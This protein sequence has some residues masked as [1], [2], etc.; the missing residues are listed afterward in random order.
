MKRITIQDRTLIPPFG[1]PARDLRLL[2][3][4]LW[5]L[6]RDLLAPYCRGAREVASLDEIPTS[7]SGELLVCKDNLYFNKALIDAFISEARASGKPC[8]IAFAAPGYNGQRHGDKSITAHALRLQ[9]GIRQQ[10][11]VYV[12]DLYYFPDGVAPEPQPLVIDTLP[13]EMGYYHIPQYMATQG[14]DLVFQVPLRAFLSIE[15]WVHVFMANSPFGVFAM[16]RAHEDV[17][18][19]ARLANFMRWKREDWSA[20]GEKLGFV[21]TTFRDKYNPFGPAWRNTFF[22]NSK[23]VKIGKNCS[24]DPTAVIHGPTIIGDNVTIGAGT[25]ITNSLIG[26]NVN[27]MQGSQVMLSIV[28]DRCYLPFNAALFMTTLMDNTMVAQNS[29]L[30]LCVVGRNTFIG[31]NNVFTDFDLIGNPIQTFHNGKLTPVGLPVLGSAIGH[32]VKIG[33]GF[34]VYPARMIGSNTT[35][36][37]A[38]EEGLVRKNV[39]GLPP[40]IVDEETGE[41]QRIVYRWPHVYQPN[42]PEPPPAPSAPKDGSAPLQLASRQPTARL[43]R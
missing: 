12:A 4:P 27:I 14:G 41:P 22:A 17:M 13:R 34:V 16:G 3:K 36:I 25:V 38:A 21:L 2:N 39:P 18:E 6:Q 9:N 19:R 1:E 11:D 35:L 37:F 42:G 15:N 23:L 10:G 26:S 29:T 28:S 8:Q 7:E 20:L 24:I 32:N 5:L 31:A 33:S 43:L 40:E 30:Q